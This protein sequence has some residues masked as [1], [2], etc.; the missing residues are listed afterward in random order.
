MWPRTDLI[1]LL[2][3]EH[4][5]LQAPMGGESTPEMAIAVGNAGGLGGLGCSY[6]S[7][8]ELSDK[9]AQIRQGTSAP[10]NLNFF[11]HSPPAE[12]PEIYAHTRERIAPFYA[13]LGIEDFPHPLEAPCDTFTQSRL[14]CLLDLRPRVVSFHFGLPDSA[15]VRALQDVGTLLISSA[16]MVAEAR[17]LNAGG[18]DAII[19]Q[20]WEAGGHRGTFHVSR[21]DFGVGGLALIPQVV[22]AV[23]VPV[24]AAGGIGD[25]R[26]IAA[27]MVLG[28]S[29]VQLGSAFLSCPEANISDAYRAALQNT[30]D[31][32]TRLS[33]A[34][35]GRPARAM[36]NRYIEAM[37]QSHHPLPD[38]PTM[39]SFSDALSL[40]GEKTGNSG[41]EF[42]LWGQAAALNR[43]RSTADLMDLLISEAQDALQAAAGKKPE[44][45]AL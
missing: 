7:N 21:E 2:D 35:S 16:T 5:L 22:D 42:Y 29:G 37:A 8:D 30:S 4:P 19:A 3:I 17:W 38:Y 27:A 23:D 6:L 39:Y 45:L 40:A 11:V 18:I 25:G 15:M 41:F 36:N 1:D 10:F 32:D 13:E 31:D 26:G 12:N 28:A 24:I 43:E 9:V 20:G 14:E 44:H 33:A 34:F